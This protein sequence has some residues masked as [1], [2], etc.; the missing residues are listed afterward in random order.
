MVQAIQ[1]SK[2]TLGELRQHFGLSEA[3]NP[4]FFTEWLAIDSQLS[5]ADAAEVSRVRGNF[6]YLLE[7]PPLLEEAVKMVVLAR[8]LDLA[9]F[10]QPP[11]RIRPELGIEISSPAED[12]A[13]V[14]GNIDVLVI[15]G[16]LWVLAIEAKMTTFA[17]NVALPQ[18]LSYMLSS[19]GAIAFGLLTNGAEFAF[20]KLSKEEK[21]I[22]LPF[23]ARF[24]LYAPGNELAAVLKDSASS[25][26]ADAQTSGRSQPSENL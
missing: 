1:A 18:A 20:V 10:Y 8:L 24:S 15:L 11:F 16:Q 25:R 2:V 23:H 13:I 21:K 6:K 12:G 5:E 9:A 17:L 19:P 3:E 4:Q 22:S 26:A 14:R 7:E